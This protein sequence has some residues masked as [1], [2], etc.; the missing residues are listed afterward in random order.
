MSLSR[1]S[2]VQTGLDSSLAGP[3]ASPGTNLV[4]M[5][6]ATARPIS[7][8]WVE[9]ASRPST[10]SSISSFASLNSDEAIEAASRAVRQRRQHKRRRRKTAAQSQRQDEA[11]IAADRSGSYHDNDDDDDVV[12]SERENSSNESDHAL[13]SSTEDLA[14]P[15]SRDLFLLSQQQTLRT[16]TSSASASLIS[17]ITDEVDDDIAASDEL[18]AGVLRPSPVTQSSSDHDSDDDTALGSEPPSYMLTAPVRTAAVRGM[19]AAISAAATLTPMAGGLQLVRES[20][21]TE[22]F[23]GCYITSHGRYHVDTTR[24]TQ[25]ATYYISTTGFFDLTAITLMRAPASAGQQKKVTSYDRHHR[26]GSPCATLFSYLVGAGALLIFSALSFSAGFALGRHEPGA[27]LPNWLDRVLRSL[28]VTP[29]RY[30][31][32]VP[33]RNEAALE[34]TDP[35]RRFK[36]EKSVQPK[37]KDEGIENFLTPEGFHYAWTDQQQWMVDN[38]NRLTAG[39]VHERSDPRSIVLETAHDPN[40]A[41]LFNYASMAHN[42]DFFWRCITDNADLQKMPEE[43]AAVI[44]E[45]CSSVRSLREEM[46]GCA[47]AMFGPGF[48]WLCSDP[49]GKVRI[50]NTY[51]AG[52][53]YA[54]AHARRQAVDANTASADQLQ[55]TGQAPHHHPDVPLFS[56][57]SPVRSYAGYG[58]G[59][60][61]RGDALAPGGLDLTPILCVNTWQS[62]WLPDYG[63][64]GKRLYL[65]RWWAHI[66][67]AQVY[68]N[69]GPTARSYRGTSAAGFHR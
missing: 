51:L 66:N 60:G 34:S 26:S 23:F 22:S 1:D 65:E 33:P 16:T 30:H 63:I 69:Y 29:G 47:E 44:A 31:H 25:Y 32:A 9:V 68:A 3:P 58:Q 42:N 28:Q 24:D 59:M 67:W 11:S 15:A 52:T 8:S 6:A 13:T 21:V 50:L 62:V 17:D 41:Q 57:T 27:A 55:G 36:C 10:T 53:P 61:G 37:W 20:E 43:M 40:Q 54:R 56:K 39:T 45:S 46:L 38:L 5:P 18:G 19:P 48:V 64:R 7:D 14:S 49:Q 35:A 4:A 2:T 12:G